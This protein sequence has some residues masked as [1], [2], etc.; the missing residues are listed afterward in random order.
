MLFFYRIV[1]M[2]LKAII[3]NFASKAIMEMQLLVLL[4]IV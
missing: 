2:V 3:V 4:Q 1:K